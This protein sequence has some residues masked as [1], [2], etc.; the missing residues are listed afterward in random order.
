MGM[1]NGNS[2][3]HTSQSHDRGHWKGGGYRLFRDSIHSGGTGKACTPSLSRRTTTTQ[4]TAFA[5]WVRSDPSRP[6]N[7]HVARALGKYCGQQAGD[8]AREKYIS[9]ASKLAKG[10][11]LYPWAVTGCCCCRP[12]TKINASHSRRPVSP[13]MG[14][15]PSAR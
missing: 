10:S 5:R 15:T 1:S 7:L 2:R 12:R 4:S 3:T 13:S 9:A 6:R 11:G 14:H 8:D